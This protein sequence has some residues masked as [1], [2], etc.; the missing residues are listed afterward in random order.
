[1]NKGNLVVI[2]L[3]LVVGG[4]LAAVY[5]WVD[6]SGRV[7]YGDSPP[8]QSDMQSVEVPEG[9]TREEVERARQEMQEKIEQY[10]GLSEAIRPPDQPE[11]PSQQAVNL[12]ATPDN[13]AC[14]S[15]LSEIIQGPSSRTYT[16]IKPTSLSK[17][18]QMSLQ[19]LFKRMEAFWRGKI[20]DLTC[21][22]S[23]SEP[24]T[25][26]TDYE[27]RTV[28][29][30]DSHIARLTLET[31]AVGRETHAVERFFHRLEV[32]DALFFTDHKLADIVALEGNKVELLN[33]THN[34]V[35]FII[36]RRYQTGSHSR[37]PRTEIRYLEISGRTLKLV[38]LYYHNETLTGSR[39]WALGS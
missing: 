21:M 23:S 28:I 25:K 14:F 26:I 36:K 7:H 35:S 5:K 1:M 18:Q 2:L 32:G 12:I 9:P 29:D 31:D 30:W 34:L 13:V 16:P 27:A 8:P 3:I 33:I 24:I 11:K 6:E 10:K 20:T 19:I 4:A 37:R 22:G 15:P 39:V 38:E 17:A